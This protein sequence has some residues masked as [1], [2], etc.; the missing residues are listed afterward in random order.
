VHG[1]K[2]SGLVPGR[3]N[4]SFE[5]TDAHGD[6]RELDSQFIVQPG[7][8]GPTGP[9]GKTG[10]QGAQG[11][12]GASITGIR[13][14]GKRG[15][16]RTVKITWKMKPQSARKAAV[17]RRLPRPPSVCAWQQRDT[18]SQVACD[19]ARRSRGQRGS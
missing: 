7:G 10:P 2:V 9:A 8:S 14:Q 3:D 4:A 16:H 13:C 12:S 1:G 18:R 6:T 19:P 5:L 17:D 15:K 11:P